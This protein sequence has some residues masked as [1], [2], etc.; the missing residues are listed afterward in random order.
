MAYLLYT[1]LGTVDLIM[2]KILIAEVKK[3]AKFG[4]DETWYR[5]SFVSFDR[6][7]LKDKIEEYYKV[8]LEK[9]ETNEF[10]WFTDGGFKYS[11][12]NENWV[13][14]TEAHWYDIV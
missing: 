3:K 4:N 10:P 11:G 5:N 2:Y 14:Q 13:F 9:D 1:L 6:D 7:K 8:K 12:E